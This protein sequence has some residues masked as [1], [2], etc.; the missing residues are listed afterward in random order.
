MVDVKKTITLVGLKQAKMGF[1]FLHESTLEEC[2]GCEFFQVCI[3][4]LKL[5]RVYK[6]IK[7]KDKIF[8]CR[9]H[10]EG[11]RVVEVIEPNIESDIDTRL[12]FPSSIITFQPQECNE[13]SC[14][15]YGKC[16]PQGLQGGDKCKILS[17]K[18]QVKCPLNRSLVLVLLQRQAD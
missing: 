17:V 11:V 6:V 5:G 10:E 18:G 2:K 16:V 7:I 3:A 8:P 13:V 1:S 14:N 12:A 9:I 4:N 15:N